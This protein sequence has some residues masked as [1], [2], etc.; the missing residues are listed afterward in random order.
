MFVV[1][2]MIVLWGNFKRVILSVFENLK[3]VLRLS[4]SLQCF[5][6]ESISSSY[7]CGLFFYPQYLVIYS[8][9]SVFDVQHA[10]LSEL[11]FTSCLHYKWW[12]FHWKLIH[13]QSKSQKHLMPFEIY[14]K[15]C[16][17]KKGSFK[18][19]QSRVLKEPQFNWFIMLH[20]CLVI[21]AAILIS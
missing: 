7:F 21:G 13:G 2:K 11:G 17:I 1:T 16:T 8:L 3:T 6:H 19:Q 9:E 20:Y 10:T 5:Y 4:V 15:C 14:V 12:H 18:T